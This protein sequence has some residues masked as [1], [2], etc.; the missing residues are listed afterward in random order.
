MI[1]ST[2]I[3]IAPTCSFLSEGF[4]SIMYALKYENIQINLF[5]YILQ[6]MTPYLVCSVLC[7]NMRFSDYRVTDR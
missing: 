1:V 7:L 4:H 6:H 2:Y 3:K 5:I